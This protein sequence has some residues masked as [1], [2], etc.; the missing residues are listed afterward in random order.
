MLQCRAESEAR[1]VAVR[2]LSQSSSCAARRPRQQP[3][4]RLSTFA[5]A[6]PGAAAPRPPPGKQLTLHS[7]FAMALP[8]T[9]LH[10]FEG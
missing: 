4:I 2:A 6:A 8:A 9:E 5:T 3:P 1:S 7:P 10:E